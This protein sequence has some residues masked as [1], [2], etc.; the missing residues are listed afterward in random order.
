M[1]L[2]KWACARSLFELPEYDTRKLGETWCTGY[3]DLV[4]SLLEEGFHN[5][6]AGNL[7][8]TLGSS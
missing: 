5:E 4:A 8:I 7:A 6:V 3:A 1:V 2:H